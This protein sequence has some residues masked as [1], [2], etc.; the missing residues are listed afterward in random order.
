MSES[1]L[2]LTYLPQSSLLYSLSMDCIENTVSNSSS[3]V[4]CVSITMDTHLWISYLGMAVFSPSTLLAFSHY[5]TTFCQLILLSWWFSS[6]CHVSVAIEYYIQHVN[7]SHQ[8]STLR[9]VQYLCFITSMMI[10]MWPSYPLFCIWN[11]KQILWLA[12][13]CTGYVFIYMFL[14]P[15]SHW[16]GGEN[17]DGPPCIARHERIPALV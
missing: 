1:Q 16:Q 12:M 7:G 3:I 15:F 5:I 2:Q 13:K 11:L 4:E 9:N 8:F 14:A 6:Y 17:V 10:F